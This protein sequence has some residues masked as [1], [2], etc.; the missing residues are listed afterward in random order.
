MGYKRAEEILPAEVVQL[1]QQ[2]VDG[3][4]IY[5]PRIENTRRTWGKGTNI[6]QEL[7]KR[8]ERIYNDYLKGKSVHELAN[9]YY[10]SIKSIQ[11]IVH[12]MGE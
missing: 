11:R 5:I 4:S 8:N 10:L 9:Q 6:R 3:E 7:R 12:Q 1:I 2:Y